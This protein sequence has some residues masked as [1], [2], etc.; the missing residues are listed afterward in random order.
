MFALQLAIIEAGVARPPPIFLTTV[1]TFAGLTPFIL[2]KSNQTKFLISLAVSLAFGA[3][4]DIFI[5]YVLVPDSYQILED[6]TS[7]IMRFLGG[8]GR[9][10]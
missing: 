2:E 1:T 7:G 9:E 4:F 8:E 10:T 3:L 6:V 5:T